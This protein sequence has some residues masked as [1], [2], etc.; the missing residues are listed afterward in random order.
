MWELTCNSEE[1]SIVGSETMSSVIPS[2]LSPQ[3]IRSVLFESPSDTVPPT[4]ELEALH[5]ELKV[6]K[7]KTLERAR[8]AGEDLKTIE[9]SMRRLK[10]KEKGKAK[11]TEKVKRE[12]GCTYYTCN[13]PNS[14]LKLD[15]PMVSL[16][17]SNL[18]TLSMR[19]NGHVLLF[20]DPSS[21]THILPSNAHAAR[22]PDVLVVI[23][24]AYRTIY[25]DSI[26][27]APAII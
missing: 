15:I 7:Q 20:N 11:A 3:P 27:T 26:L 2:Y 25:R 18:M 24:A 1:R 16:R 21:H 22:L 13:K 5:A 19:L 6:V 10:E 14:P 12:R 9:E 23:A 17:P 8:K 4:D